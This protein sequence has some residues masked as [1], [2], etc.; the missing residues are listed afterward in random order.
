M[1]F[2]T[3]QAAVALARTR[4]VMLTDEVVVVSKPSYALTQPGRGEHQQQCV[5][6]WLRHRPDVARHLERVSAVRGE[7]APFVVHRLDMATSGLLVLAM[8]KAVLAHLGK[9]FAGRRVV[10]EY[11]ALVR[12]TPGVLALPASGTIS[13][14]LGTCAGCMTLHQCPCAT[15]AGCSPCLQSGTP[16]GASCSRLRRLDLRR[17]APP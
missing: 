10:K 4:I 3:V 14:P 9:E 13:M 5:Q 6:S 12:A 11:A 1:A 7:Q 17:A 8:N 2:R 16:S 15:R